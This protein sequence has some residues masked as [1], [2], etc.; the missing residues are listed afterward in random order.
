MRPS[1]E[2][3]LAEMIRSLRNDSELR[4]TVES[5]LREF[6]EIGRMGSDIWMKEMTFCLLAANYSA[7]T[8]YR[9]AELLFSSNLLFRGSKEDIRDMLI[10]EGYR[11]PNRSAYIVNAR[12]IIDEIRSVVPDLNDFKARD[13]LVSRVKG[14]GMKESSHF[15]RNTGRKNLAIV[16][17]HIIRVSVEYGLIDHVR[18]LTRRRYLEIEEKLREVANRLEITLAELDLYLWYTK[19][20]FVFR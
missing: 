5:R 11:F 12:E 1:S 6:E 10:R 17:R 19:T 7:V 3:A 2:N 4:R 15:L 13:Y 16:D 18:S 8:A 9:I 14:F 20:G